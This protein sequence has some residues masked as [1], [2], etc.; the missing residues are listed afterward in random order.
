M[1]SRI[2]NHLKYLT[3]RN[4]HPLTPEHIFYLRSKIDNSLLELAKVSGGE[5]KV[6]E[7]LDELEK[8]DN[9]TI[10]KL[11]ELRGVSEIT[12]MLFFID[13]SLSLNSCT[14]KSNQHGAVLCRDEIELLCNQTIPLVFPLELLEETQK[15]PAACKLRLGNRYRLDNGPYMWLS[16]NDKIEIPPHGIAIVSTY[17]WINMPAYLIGRW[18]LRVAKVYEGLVWVGGPQ[19]DPGFQGFLSCPLYNLSN[20]YRSLT[21]KDQ[22]FTIDFVKVSPNEYLRLWN[23]PS[24]RY[25]TF[26]FDR[27]DRWKIQSAPKAKF[28]ELENRMKS[29]DAKLAVSGTKFEH[30]QNAMYAFIGVVVALIAIISTFGL[31]TWKW[32]SSW[33]QVVLALSALVLSGCALAISILNFK[34]KS[35][36]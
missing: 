4:I 36:K 33:V 3:T 16:G 23:K 13:N 30:F 21:Y 6:I 14:Q 5:G 1:P 2:P 7:Y 35:K 12:W 15:D 10:K 29:L 34:R 32:N 11:V 25:A 22:L 26:N 27:L 19:V 31:G 20:D 18:N 28:D 24:D 9:P 8:T 17:E